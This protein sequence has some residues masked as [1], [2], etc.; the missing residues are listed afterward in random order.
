MVE[1]ISAAEYLAQNARLGAV[2]KPHKYG[3]KQ[4]EVDGIK[5]PSVAEANRYSILML[6]FRA[7][8]ITRLRLQPRFA[9]VCDDASGAPG[10]K[11]EVAEYVADFRYLERVDTGH[12]A[13]SIDVVEDVKGY[14]TPVY[15]LKIKLFKA[16]YP[17]L[18]FREI[19]AP[20]RSRRRKRKRLKVTWPL[21]K[22]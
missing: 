12:S 13:G 10:A 2:R 9:L 5:F 11:I 4:K 19:K 14:L 21:I 16:Q 6:R 15:R 7:G 17:Q 1:R 18:V 22:T 3:A 20:S 8:E